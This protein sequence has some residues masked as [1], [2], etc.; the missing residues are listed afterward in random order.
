MTVFLVACAS[1]GPEVKVL[2]PPPSAPIAAFAIEKVDIQSR[3]TGQA[4]WARNEDYAA[5]LGTALRQA[6]RERGK[7]ETD[8][9]AATIRMRVYLATGAAP[10]QARGSK[11]A[12]AFVEARIQL[13]EAGS[14]AVRYSTHTRT[15]LPVNALEEQLTTDRDQLIRDTLRFAAQDFVSRL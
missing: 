14:G 2:T 11:T 9:P 13:V 6:L 10:V 4:A 5:Y 3:E 15:A 7:T 1:R 8:P 12:G